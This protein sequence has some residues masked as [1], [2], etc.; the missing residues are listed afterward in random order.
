MILRHGLQ[1]AKSC[2]WNPLFLAFHQT[3]VCKRP[4]GWNW[5]TKEN[6]VK[7]VWGIKYTFEIRWWNGFVS[8]TFTL[9]YPR[10]T[11]VYTLCL[12]DPLISW[13][14]PCALY[15]RKI[16]EKTRAQASRSSSDKVMFPLALQR[17]QRKVPVG[18]HRPTDQIQFCC[19]PLSMLA[20]Q[21]K[22]FI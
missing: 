6:G 17:L 1:N 4:F 12:A 15:T 20:K 19:G 22:A 14:W 2:S 18:T 16:T 11:T 7:P 13:W 5:W 8:C 21:V 10:I 3:T 9:S